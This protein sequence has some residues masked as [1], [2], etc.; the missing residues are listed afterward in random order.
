MKIHNCW[1]NGENN[2]DPLGWKLNSIIMEDFII[3][4]LEWTNEL[5][6][7]ADSIQYDHL[8]LQK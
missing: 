5:N 7:E 6:F 1:C 8:L 3:K 4:V 2:A